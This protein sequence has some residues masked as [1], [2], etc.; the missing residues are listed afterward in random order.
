VC[1]GNDYLD[2]R[3]GVDDIRGGAGNDVSRGG[4]GKDEIA[5]GAGDDWLIGEGGND[6]LSGGPGNDLLVG[7]AGK[8]KFVF[9]AALAPTNVDHV[10]DFSHLNDRIDL[11]HAI[12][13]AIAAG[14]LAPVAGMIDG[15]EMALGGR[16]RLVWLPAIASARVGR[17][18]RDACGK[19]LG[20]GIGERRRAWPV[21]ERRRSVPSRSM[22]SAICGREALICG[23][24]VE[25]GRGYSYGGSRLA[26][27]ST[28]IKGTTPRDS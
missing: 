16:P 21:R 19:S 8:D 9:D 11:S 1:G 3:D 15:F 17:R 10:S 14:R 28:P 27:F 20:S 24:A 25:A 26:M 2:G 13:T 22:S 7:G 5:G 12:F 18:W 6:I 4:G 23:C